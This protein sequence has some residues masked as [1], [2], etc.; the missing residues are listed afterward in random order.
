MKK[1]FD[2]FLELPTAQ[3]IGLIVAAVAIVVAVALIVSRISFR[4][5]QRFAENRST[6]LSSKRRD[7][8][9]IG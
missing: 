6:H 2:A 8:E 9:S 4:A 7:L 1:L 5:G 3:G